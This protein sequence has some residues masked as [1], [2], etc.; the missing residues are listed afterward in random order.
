MHA[1]MHAWRE[2]G[3][4]GWTDEPMERPKAYL[5]PEQTHPQGVAQSVVL[6]GKVKRGRVGQLV[7]L[8]HLHPPLVHVEHVRGESVGD[9]HGGRW[10]GE[11]G[12][13]GKSGPAAFFL[14]VP[15]SARDHGVVASP[16]D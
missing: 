11:G 10:Q 7:V 2:G 12:E 1:C 3:R 5:V 9:I 14:V 13:E 16:G 4:E 6:L 8:H 15:L